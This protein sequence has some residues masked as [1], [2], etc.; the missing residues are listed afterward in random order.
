MK[1]GQKEE[2]ET[3]NENMSRALLETFADACATRCKDGWLGV[4]L[5]KKKWERPAF[6]IF[7]MDVDVLFD[8]AKGEFGVGFVCRDSNGSLVVAGTQRMKPASTAMKAEI[9]AVIQGIYVCMKHN[10]EAV[11]IFTDS[12]LAA[13]AMA[14]E[15]EDENCLPAHLAEILHA[16]RE[17]FLLNV[18]HN[19]YV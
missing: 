7:R 12:L 17:N 19:S 11:E 14:N 3:P 16:A 8:P 5:G 2:Y 6:R 9:M 18:H 13:R 4:K 1:H 15:K 10:V